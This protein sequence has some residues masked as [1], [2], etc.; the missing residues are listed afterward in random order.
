[1]SLK[2]TPVIILPIKIVMA[3]QNVIFSQM[4]ITL[5][6]TVASIHFIKYIVLSLQQLH[7]HNLIYLCSP[8]ILSNHYITASE[9]IN[10]PCLRGNQ[11]NNTDNPS[12]VVLNN[13]PDKNEIKG[14]QKNA[15]IWYELDSFLL[16]CHKM[17]S[18]N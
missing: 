16:K 13:T 3:G 15:W 2:F 8:A 5:V 12:P 9:A 1:M 6:I 7:K 17:E 18:F 14:F 4:K 10:Q 11:P